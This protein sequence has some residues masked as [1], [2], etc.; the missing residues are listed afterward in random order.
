MKLATAALLSVFA[1]ALAGCVVHPSGTCGPSCD[2][3]GDAAKI[4]LSSERLDVMNA[5]ATRRFL[6]Q[7]EQ[8][9]LVNGIIHGGVGGDQSDPLIT[10]IH[11]PCCTP[12]TRRYI[13][14]RL[15]FITYSRE[16]RRVAET[17]SQTDT[18][19]PPPGPLPADETD[20]GQ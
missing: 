8:F 17:L 5:V 4:A 19:N 12:E 13:S 3:I 10:L 18:A 7:H 2:D 9:Y 20:P 1:T 6:S 15:Q 11:N 16:R 14:E